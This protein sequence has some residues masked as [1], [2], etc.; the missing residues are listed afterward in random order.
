VVG[1]SAG[2]EPILQVAGLRKSYDGRKALAGI[3]LTIAPGEICALLGPN[4]AGKTTLVSIVAGLRS[5]DAGTVRVRGIDAVADS[6]AARQ[7]IGLAPQDL[8]VYPSIT[9]RA[10]LA[11]FGELAGIRGA[12][13]AAR[14]DEVAA[15]LELG[16]LLDRK[17]AVLSGGERR[18]VH[19]AMALMHQ[20]PLLL[21]DEVTTGVDIRTRARLLEAVR[22]LAADGAAVCYSTHYLPEVEQLGATVAIIDGGR[23]LAR[24]S[25]ADLVAEH[26]T[27]VVEVRFDGPA[28]VVQASDVGAVEVTRI[29][30][31]TLRVATSHPGA[32]AAR[33]VALGEAVERLRNVE[34]VAANLDSVFLA[35]TG[36]RYAVE[37]LDDL[38]DL[39]RTEG[40]ADAPPA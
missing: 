23:L 29:G 2:G 14:T 22:A 16:E 4:G 21:L 10:N 32:T 38:D 28:P 27:A 11:L 19:T 36:R 25:I 34:I 15:A 9:A 31:D 30:E 24:G 17:V 6:V 7:S 33:L 37:D 35:I 8:G 12:A 40:M 39:D 1:A 3:D 20:P 26:A 13:L 18:R 5:P